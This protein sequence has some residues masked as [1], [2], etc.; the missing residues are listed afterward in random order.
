MKRDQEL[1]RSLLFKYEDAAEWLLDAPGVVQDPD[2]EEEREAYHVE[3]MVD[4][5]LLTYVSEYTMRLTS[6]GHDYLDAIRDD[7]I[8]KKTK[9]GAAAVG[10]ATLGIMVEI[11]VAYEKQAAAEKLG[12]QLS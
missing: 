11:A 10:G 7:G 3:L 9:E 12:I 6:K 8:W 1:I 5:G 4:A 2:E